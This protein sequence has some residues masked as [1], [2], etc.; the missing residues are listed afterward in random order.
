MRTSTAV[1]LFGVLSAGLGAGFIAANGV[2]SRGC[3]AVRAF[4]RAAEAN[5]AE[6][7]R[8]WCA[9]GLV[10]RG[11]TGAAVVEADIGEVPL[12]AF[13]GGR[14]CDV[15]RG[16]RCYLGLPGSEIISIRPGG[17]TVYTWGGKITAF[18]CR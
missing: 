13:A 5:D 18:E 12:A 8:L 15:R 2:G 9:T 6:A 7:A 3:R 17:A 10:R 11:P 1:F 14:I 16:R 4:V